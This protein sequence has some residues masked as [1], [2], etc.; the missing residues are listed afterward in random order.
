VTFIKA[1]LQWFDFKRRGVKV[2]PGAYVYTTAK[3]GNCVSIGRNAEIGNK[4]EIGANSK[5]GAGAFLPE[6]VV[7]GEGCF[8]GP[9]AIFS[10]DMYPPSPKSLWK[11]TIVQDKASVGAGVKVRPGITIRS[12]AMVGMGAV[13]TRDVGSN[14]VV[15]GVPAKIIGDTRNGK[16]TRRKSDA[17][18][19]KKIRV[20]KEEH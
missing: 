13:V 7:I 9:Y 20:H 19:N 15:A 1:I 11:K 4:V 17:V 18:A 3:V 6:G 12:G 8:I 2:W 14:E 10:N 16:N 5:I